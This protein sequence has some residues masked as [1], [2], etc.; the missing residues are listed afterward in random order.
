[1]VGMK[2]KEKEEVI[3]AIEKRKMF[4]TVST[5]TAEAKQHKEQVTQEAT[6]N[7]RPKRK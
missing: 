5:K 7:R 6:R 3:P 2:P 1:M 4:G